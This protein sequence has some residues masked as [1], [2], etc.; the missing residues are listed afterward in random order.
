MRVQ[1]D[2]QN[3]L[4]L[5]DLFPFGDQKWKISLEPHFMSRTNKT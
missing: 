5:Q 3:E 2:G 4:N 1:V